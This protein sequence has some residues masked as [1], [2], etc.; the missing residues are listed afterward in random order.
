MQQMGLRV[1]RIHAGRA[2]LFLSPIFREALA[3][4][5]G[6]TIELYDTDGSVGAARG[7]GIGAGIYVSPEEAFATLEKLAVIEPVRRKPYRD[8]YE[9]W[10][11]YLNN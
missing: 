6:A 2:N 4:T 7:A 11:S 3:G 5:S 1:D 9:Q 10:K 8:A